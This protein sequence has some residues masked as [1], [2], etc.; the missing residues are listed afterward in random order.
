VPTAGL[1][2]LALL[3]G[4]SSKAAAQDVTVTAC[5]A[6][7]AGGRPAADGTIVNHS[8]KASTY[9]IDIIFYDS[10]GNR[11]SEGG[12]TVGKVEP[13]ATATFHAGGL[14]SAK[15]PL[16]CKVASVTRTVAP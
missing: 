16:T 8:S 9:V 10:S 5:Q 15:G 7:P 4:C 13:G 6:D 2:T 11:A 14:A 1:L 12:A 3:G